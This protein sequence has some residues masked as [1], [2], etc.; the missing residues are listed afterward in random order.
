[1]PGVT[2]D[3]VFVTRKEFA[4][5]VAD[6]QMIEWGENDTSGHLYGTLIPQ[7]KEDDM[8]CGPV[9]LTKVRLIC[10]PFSCARKGL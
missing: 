4:K 10:A 9:K 1:M 8:P 5:L 7:E 3:Y 2:E 6:N